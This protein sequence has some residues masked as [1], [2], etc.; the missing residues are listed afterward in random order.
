MLPI[1][2]QELDSLWVGWY[3][4]SGALRHTT[5]TKRSSAC[6]KS[7]REEF[8]WSWVMMTFPIA[9]RWCSWVR[10]CLKC[11]SFNEESAFNF[12]YNR[13]TVYGWAWWFTSHHQKQPWIWSCFAHRR[14]R[15][16]P[17]RISCMITVFGWAWWFVS[18]HSK[19]T[20]MDMVK[21][22]PE[23]CKKMA[24]QALFKSN[25]A[26]TARWH[27]GGGF[28]QCWEGCYKR[29][30]DLDETLTPIIKGFYQEKGLTLDALMHAPPV[31]DFNINEIGL[32]LGR[33]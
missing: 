23:K 29:I 19:I 11:S 26:G 25:W 1:E 16:W 10:L 22:F 7:K 28:L 5:K 14:A 8:L 15:R 27:D 9:F 4:N 33:S 21:F 3:V 12:L 30:V 6:F 20:T 18:H 31:L 24:L 13:F 32:I 17:Y 2:V